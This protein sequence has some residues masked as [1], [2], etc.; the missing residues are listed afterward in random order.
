M[1]DIDCCNL[2]KR[3]SRFQ[4]C[5]VPLSL[6]GQE[7]EKRVY[8]EGESTC[9][10]D[11]EKLTVI[12]NNGFKEQYQRSIKVCLGKEARFKPLNQTTVRRKSAQGTKS[13]K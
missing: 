13:Q 5:S 12:A 4:R 2:M 9:R 11:F 3:C 8:L 6:L 7:I 1:K 10:L